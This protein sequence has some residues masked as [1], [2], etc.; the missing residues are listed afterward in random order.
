[1]NCA[2]QNYLGSSSSGGGSGSGSRL[3][4]AAKNYLGYSQS[5]ALLLSG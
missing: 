4:K 2:V 3:S 1:M 5:N